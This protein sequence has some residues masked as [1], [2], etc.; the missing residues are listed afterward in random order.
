V[1][2]RVRLGS[3]SQLLPSGDAN[4]YY[5][6]HNSNPNSNTNFNPNFNPD[7]N[8]NLNFDPNSNPNLTVV[9][10]SSETDNLLPQTENEKPKPRRKSSFEALRDEG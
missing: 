6:C 5:Y 7:F 1:R 4:Y 10:F 2:V 3:M 9:N 8:P